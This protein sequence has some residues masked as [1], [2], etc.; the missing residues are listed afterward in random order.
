MSRSVSLSNSM[1][2]SGSPCIFN[3]VTTEE[4][5][6]LY[7]AAAD[8]NHSQETETFIEDQYLRGAASS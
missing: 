6:F 8:Y 7:A 2:V 4:V 1:S 3:P 5:V